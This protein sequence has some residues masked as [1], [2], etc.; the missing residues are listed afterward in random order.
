MLEKRV[1][2]LEQDVRDIRATMQ[3]FEILLVEI[4]ASLLNCATKDE[5]NGL[6]S[7]T[8]AIQATMA[9]RSDLEDLRKDTIKLREDTAE[10]KGQ[11]KN[12]P[13]TWQMITFMTASQIAFAGI[14]FTA[15]KFGLK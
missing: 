4:R 6:R 13:S 9:T 7:E 8:A 10:I 2:N 15:L 3:R 5:I 14:L 1:E 11:L 12:I